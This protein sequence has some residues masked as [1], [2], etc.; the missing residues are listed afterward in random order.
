MGADAVLG[1]GASTLLKPAYVADKDRA[2]VAR[3]ERA[4]A[5]TVASNAT[6]DDDRDLLLDMLG[7]AP[8]EGTS[9]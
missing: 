9:S 5:R 8:T 2:L 4:A 6:S 1:G 7:L 3:L